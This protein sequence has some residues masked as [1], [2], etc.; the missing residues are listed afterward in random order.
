MIDDNDDYLGPVSYMGN[1]VPISDSIQMRPVWRR[2][3]LRHYMHGNLEYPNE[4]ERHD[5]ILVLAD[6]E[7]QLFAPALYLEAELI[8]MEASS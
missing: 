8:F 1:H 5:A 2:R 4:A 3:Q 7:N 6:A